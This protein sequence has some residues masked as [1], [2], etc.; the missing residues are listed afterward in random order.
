MACDIAALQ[1][2]AC[3]QGYN[4]L[5][6]RALLEAVVVALCN[7]TG[8]GGATTG[9]GSPEGVVT[10][11]VGALYIN[12]ATN[13]IWFKETGTGNTGWTQVAGGT[14]GVGEILTGAFTDPNG[15]VTPTTTTGAALY[16]QDSAS[17]VNQWRWSVADQVWYQNM[18]P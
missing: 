16:Y 2:E 12:T 13:E 7:A 15:N 5:S 9:V 8:G 6:Q 18:G 10:A 4:G 14:G 11:G 1:S 17:A 3:A